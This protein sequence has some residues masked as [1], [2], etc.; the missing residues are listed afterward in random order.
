M[1]EELVPQA[2]NA[3]PDGML[4]DPALLGLGK[5][6]QEEKNFSL[7]SSTSGFLPRLMLF[8]SGSNAVKEDK[9]KQGNYGIVR[10]KEIEDL[11]R[12]VPFLAFSW[13]PKALETGG[14]EVISMFDPNSSEFKRIAAKSEEKD[15]GCM[16]GPEYFIWMPSSQIPCFVTFFMCSKTARR[17]APMVKA[18]INKPGLF[19]STLIKNKKY[20]WWGPVVT[21]YSGVV[22]SKPERAELIEQL[23]K[24]N[25]PPESTTESAADVGEREV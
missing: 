14:D 5:H 9:I 16:F 1:S 17:E 7:V 6:A 20:S 25:N 21:P 12:E 15:S 19:K 10:G 11:T 2:E 18:L 8:A 24:F 23:A 3:V 13:R 4:V 22:A